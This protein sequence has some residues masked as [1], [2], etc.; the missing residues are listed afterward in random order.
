MKP[1]LILAI[2]FGVLALVF[3]IML[4]RFY[5]IIPLPEDSCNILLGVRAGED[6]TTESLQ[7]RFTIP[8]LEDTIIERSETGYACKTKKT[9]AGY[10]EYSATMTPNEYEIVVGVIRRASQNHY[11][12][13]EIE[14]P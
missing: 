10:E 9:V 13:P 3:S 5:R 14:K 12:L 8:C 2:G 4:L 11:R 7:F 1:L 6:I